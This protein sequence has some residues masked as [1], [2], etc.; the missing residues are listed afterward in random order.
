VGWVLP[1]PRPRF[2]RIGRAAAQP[3]S[4]HTLLGSSAHWQMRESTLLH[5]IK[6]SGLPIPVG[7]VSRAQLSRWLADS[8]FLT[9]DMTLLARTLSVC[10]SVCLIQDSTFGCEGS[11]AARQ[12]AGYSPPHPS[13]LGRFHCIR[14]GAIKSRKFILRAVNQERV[15]LEILGR[16]A[17]RILKHDIS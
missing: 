8:V 11:E 5:E 3:C 14:G 6:A 7:S 9:S 4:N 1:R 15:S 12:P 2:C 17:N 10:L 16:R 13:A